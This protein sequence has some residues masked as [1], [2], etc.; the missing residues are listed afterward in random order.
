MLFLALVVRQ[1]TLIYGVT[2]PKLKK[3]FFLRI[4]NFVPNT[5]EMEPKL[6]QKVLDAYEYYPA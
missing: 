6:L 1:K 2:G 3:F 4:R 5:I